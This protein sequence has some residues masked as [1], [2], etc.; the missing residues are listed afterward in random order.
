MGERIS[1]ADAQTMYTG[2]VCEHKGD[3]VYVANID[4]NYQV[5]MKELLS[6]KLRQA[7][8]DTDEF[9]APSNGRL[10]YVNF[11]SVAMYI[12]RNPRRMYKNGFTYQ[13]LTFK[14]SDGFGYTMEELD[15]V[16]LEC[17][18]GI[19]NPAF[20]D[21]YT[22]KF[23]SFEEAVAQVLA[24][25]ARIIAFDRQFALSYKGGVYYKNIHVGQIDLRRQRTLDQIKWK[26]EW[27]SIIRL[28]GMFK[29]EA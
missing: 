14:K 24:K 21:T 17:R 20:V 4:G 25:D 7:V 9:S 15:F 11:G 26:P 3:L 19:T 16:Q 23:P 29:L 13:N 22:G 10:G 6:G 8:F 1:V 28:V 5:L 18:Q 27:D 12:M 2:T